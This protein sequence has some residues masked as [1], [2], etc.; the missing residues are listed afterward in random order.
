MKLQNFKSGEVVMK[1]SL[2]VLV[3]LA[4]S[5]MFTQSVFAQADDQTVTFVVSAVTKLAVSGDPGVLNITA[6]TAGTDALTPVS[7]ATTTYSITHN[8]NSAL[9]ITGQIT[10][11]GDMPAGTA[12]K[13][14][15]VGASGGTGQGSQTLTSGSPVDL[16][17]GIAKGADAAKLITYTLEANASAGT[18]AST[19]RTVTLTLTN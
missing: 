4:L 6:G 16:V 14:A 1:K 7:D 9:K 8:S 17:T 3:V 13:V 15:L 5:L 12:L 10:A 2:V 11:N 19:T 18:I